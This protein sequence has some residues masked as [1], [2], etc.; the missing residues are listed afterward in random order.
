MDGYIVD[1]TKRYIKICFSFQI[2]DYLDLFSQDIT[3]LESLEDLIFFQSIIDYE[4]PDC[5]FTWTSTE[6]KLWAMTIPISENSMCKSL[7]DHFNN[8]VTGNGCCKNC[9]Q[10]KKIDMAS[11]PSLNKSPT[12]KLSDIE[13]EL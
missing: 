5:R 7:E 9:H 13:K 10:T 12:G 11:C 4:C 8:E 2:E 1:N 6:Y 3:N